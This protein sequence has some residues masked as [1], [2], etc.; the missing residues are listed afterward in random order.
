MVCNSRIDMTYLLIV[1]AVIIVIGFLIPNWKHDKVMK[2]NWEFIKQQEKKID[3]SI[4]D[5]PSLPTKD[6]IQSALKT[7]KPK[8]ILSDGETKARFDRIN[9][10]VHPK[11]PQWWV[12][13]YQDKNDA[14]K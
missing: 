7:P 6:E 3:D 1:L 4:K 10:T 13:N 12:D 2:K 8:V 11:Q 5:T 9:P 14:E